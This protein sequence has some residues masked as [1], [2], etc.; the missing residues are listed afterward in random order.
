MTSDCFS[1]IYPKLDGEQVFRHYEHVRGRLP[2]TEFPDRYNTASA[3]LEIAD[4]FDVFV[5]DAYGVLNIGNQPIPGAAECVAG[6][7]ALGKQ[8]MV[9]SNGASFGSQANVEK[10]ASLG[11]DFSTGELVSSRIAAQRV[12]Q[13]HGDS[14]FWGAMA[15]ADYQPS[16]FDQPT[17][18][19]ADEAAIYDNVT[20][21][22]LLSTLDWNEKRCQLL[23][24][25][26]ELNPR[27]VI[28]ANPD[29]VSPRE[30]YF[31]IEP[32]YIG[33]RLVE[34]L[35]AQVTFHGKP[36]GSVFDIVE[37]R[38]A[39]NVSGSRICMIGDTLHTDI[40]GGAAR[41]WKTILV[42]SHGMFKGMDASEY[43]T[44][45][46]IVPDWVMPSI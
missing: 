2:M 8:I 28:V 4:Q 46:G 15:K 18:K 7:R 34:I 29:I 9:L 24:R 44:R 6:L 21:F 30:K 17:I 25:S 3:L 10:F 22:L 23:E 43:I 42:C 26:M 32:G 16:E 39:D 19:L 12:L 1:E 33:H 36:F 13:S 37:E 14:I 38:L 27:P 31:G 11:Y 5:F 45:S 41:G 35:G 40:L 20:G